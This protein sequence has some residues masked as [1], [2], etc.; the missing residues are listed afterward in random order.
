MSRN[1]SLLFFAFSFFSIMCVQY[2]IA[3]S[4]G[5]RIINDND[6]YKM[7]DGT[8]R[9]Y[10][11]G[12]SIEF[13]SQ[14]KIKRKRLRLA[15]PQVGS[16]T[17]RSLEIRYGFTTQA[18][19]PENAY[20]LSGQLE[21]RPYAGL[22]LFS[23]TGISN[24][25]NTNRRLTTSYSLGMIGPATKQKEMQTWFHT[26]TNRKQPVGWENQI[27]NDLALNTA[28]QY[29]W[30]LWKPAKPIEFTGQIEANCG[31]LMNFAGIGGEFRLG[32]MND[33]FRNTLGL[34]LHSPISDFSPGNS[35]E[36]KYQFYFFGKGMGRVVLD[37]S[38]LEA[39]YFNFKNSPYRLSKAQIEKFYAQF[40]FGYV[41][42][43]PH[44]SVSF[45]QIYRT[46]EYKGGKSAQWGSVALIIG[47]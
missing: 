17:S 15:F 22:A 37:N 6:Y 12:F 4:T 16:A 29:E 2:G 24:D 20:T 5:I 26:I 40:E 9:Y 35:S 31:S 45:S 41:F 34:S 13:Q 30:R 25:A 44:F 43:A 21:S 39:G 33:Y 14:M 46:A 19:T 18:Y 28:A 23:A 47:L 7:R 8:D 36:R 32:F 38:L 10:T 3:Q 11:N 1:L 42:A 27:A